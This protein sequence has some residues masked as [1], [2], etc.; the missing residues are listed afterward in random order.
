MCLKE[1]IICRRRS[2]KERTSRLEEVNETKRSGN[3]KA[4]E[5]AD[6]EKKRNNEEGSYGS[7]IIVSPCSSTQTP[8]T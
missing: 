4:A 1:R 5:Q 3:E 2:V 8:D 6:E 7:F